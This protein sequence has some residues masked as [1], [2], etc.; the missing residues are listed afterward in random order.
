MSDTSRKSNNARVPLAFR[1]LAFLLIIAVE[2]WLAVAVIDRFTLEPSKQLGKILYGL[3]VLFLVHALFPFS[4]KIPLTVIATCAVI[5][6][7]LGNS[8]LVVIV[9]GLVLFGLCHLPIAFR[10][11]VA[12]VL[13]ATAGLACVRA[14]WIPAD[15]NTLS[16]IAVVGALF[17]FRLIIYLYDLRNEKKR[18]GWW[19]RLGY[20]FMLPNPVFP[21]FPVVD[22]KVY[23]RTHYS[24]PAL[25]TYQTGALWIARG[26]LHLLL[27]RVVYYYL[28]PSPEDVNDYPGVLQYCFSAYLL[29]LRVSG[30]FHLIAGI[31]YLFG[32]QLPETHRRYLFASG[33]SD[34]WRRINIYWKDFMTKVVF[35]PAIV[36]LKGLGPNGAL[37]VAT[38]IVFVATTI[39]HS[40]QWF[41]LKGVFFIEETDYWFWGIFGLLVAINNVAEAKRARTTNTQA[42]WSSGA[43]LKL[44]IQTAAM[45]VGMCLIW[46]MWTSHTLANW[47]GVVRHLGDATVS[48]L[49]VTAGLAAIAVGIGWFCLWAH[50]R[51][52][53]DLFPASPGTLRSILS[54]TGFLAILLGAWL[55]HL[56]SG[57]PGEVGRG[58]DIVRSGQLNLRDQELQERGYYE[59]LLASHTRN[60]TGDMID[61]GRADTDAGGEAVVV[62]KVDFTNN[63]WFSPVD[64]IRFKSLRP[65]V[66]GTFEGTRSSTNRWGMRDRDYA[67]EKPANTVRIAMLGASYTMGLGVGDDDT[68]ENFVEVKLNTM[69]ADGQSVEILNFGVSDYC[70][71][72]S[73]LQ[74]EQ[75]VMRFSPDVVMLIAHGGER[76]RVATKMALRIHQE[77]PLT[78]EYLDRMKRQMVLIDGMAYSDAVRALKPRGKEILTWAYESMAAICKNGNAKPVWVFLPTMRRAAA[79]NHGPM[80]KLAA[81]AGFATIILDEPYGGIDPEELK[82]TETNYHPNARGH[83]L[84]ADSLVRAIVESQEV[85][86]SQF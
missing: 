64:D 55:Y 13:L 46:S 12:L 6:A 36:R 38:G 50:Q 45:F 23:Q 18:A 43:T 56:E 8:G 78:F 20:F 48:Q 57:I 32:F 75:E 70:T 61:A 77:H 62:D 3:P 22:W 1:D 17:M 21:L 73:L 69:L 26:I 15:S 47:W 29:Y 40:Y 28:T 4:W 24:G 14:G 9:A 19:T 59:G 82:I 49:S 30:L 54:T 71:L 39:L 44:C 53:L 85:L 66:S 51:R 11:R 74:L 84:I 52:G 42:N 68:F 25:Q 67:L 58:F 79:A 81:K 27:Y 16:A 31:M 5:V 37:A 63:P 86:D 35:F 65:N 34:Y 2:V 33:F 72:E 10:M 41:W 80:E 7:T 60:Y 76:N 83:S